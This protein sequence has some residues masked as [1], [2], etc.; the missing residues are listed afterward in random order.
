MCGKNS[1]KRF[2][3]TWSPNATSLMRFNTYMKKHKK[4]KMPKISEKEAAE[5]AEACR[6]AFGDPA[7]DEFF[8]KE[9]EEVLRLRKLR[10]ERGQQSRTE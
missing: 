4:F 7:A 5:L 10:L 3:M 9:M 6:F 2:P 1:E 8:D